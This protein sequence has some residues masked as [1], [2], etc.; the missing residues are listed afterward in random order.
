MIEFSA[1]DVKNFEKLAKSAKKLGVISVKLGNLEFSFAANFESLAPR[2]A[3]KASKK[4]QAEVD[5]RN[6]DQ[7]EFD[8]VKDE[9]AI[10]HVEDPHGFEQALIENQFEDDASEGKLEETHNFGTE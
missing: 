7:L 10:M 2:P 5:Q 4:E 3:F 9:L 1:K 8:A 6:V